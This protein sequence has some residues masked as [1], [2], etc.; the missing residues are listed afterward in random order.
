M[1]EVK[2][3]NPADVVKHINAIVNM[4]GDDTVVTEAKNPEY[5]GKTRDQAAKIGLSKYGIDDQEASS[6]IWADNTIKDTTATSSDIDKAVGIRNKTFDKIMSKGGAKIKEYSPLIPKGSG[7]ST[8]QRIIGAYIP[9]PDLK[10]YLQKQGYDVQHDLNTNRVLVK[11][12]NEVQWSEFNPNKIDVM[13]FIDKAPDVI[14]GALTI[15]LSKAGPLG[16]AISAGIGAGSEALR[17]ATSMAVGGREKGDIG[18]SDIAQSGVIS[19]GL[20]AVAEGV[21]AVAKRVGPAIKEIAATKALTRSEKPLLMDAAKKLGIEFT[22]EELA[23]SPVKRKLFDAIQKAD[24]SLVGYFTGEYSQRKAIQGVGGR[25][26]KLEDISSGILD[27]ASMRSVGKNAEE[28]SKSNIGLIKYN[29]GDEVRKTVAKSIKDKQEVASELYDKVRKTLNLKDFK[30]DMSVLDKE[31]SALKNKFKGNSEAV[32]IVDSVL[33][34][35]KEVTS[36]NEVNNIRS[37]LLS[38][39]RVAGKSGDAV[40]S[41]VYSDLATTMKNVEDDTYVKLIDKFSKGAE[42]EFLATAKNAEK[43]ANKDVSPLFPKNKNIKRLEQAEQMKKDLATARTLWRDANEEGTQFYKATGEDWLIDLGPKIKK[44]EGGQAEK[45]LP[46]IVAEGDVEKQR[47]MAKRYPE[48]W[49]K[50]TRAS[51]AEDVQNIILSLSEGQTRNR[52]DWSKTISKLSKLGGEDLS[53]LLGADARDKLEALKV[54]HKYAPELINASGTRLN[55]AIIKGGVI[56]K[57]KE[58]FG[59]W[60]NKMAYDATGSGKVANILDKYAKGITVG[61]KQIEGPALTKAAGQTIIS[62][63]KGGE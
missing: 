4:I 48:L 32:G 16:V 56:Q 24:E 26:D 50:A 44:I 2:E 18:W 9:E 6:L 42:N 13:D 22:E 58:A 45:I 57:N 28:L 35:A 12:P 27:E 60:L 7:V 15:P 14:E 59:R 8:V 30:A 62:S 49:D 10:N 21:G 39:A 37:M 61:G 43:Y 53:I 11:R 54:V 34:Q 5:R 47:L 20:G 46:K 55:E 1:A 33:A 17:Q 23:R 25:L 31:A 40:T 36:L 3:R 51:K 38:K 63:Q 52:S 19:G 29:M 41:K